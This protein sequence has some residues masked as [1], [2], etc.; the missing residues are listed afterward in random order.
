MCSAA[1]DKG[2]NRLIFSF[3]LG[4]R[5]IG[6]RVSCPALR[7]VPCW[8]PHTPLLRVQV[9]VQIFR[10]P[11]L[12]QAPTL[13]QLEPLP[14]SNPCRRFSRRSELSPLFSHYGEPFCA[15][16]KLN[17]FVFK[18]FGILSAKH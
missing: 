8:G 10:I 6:F 7:H 1:G 14:P 3:I 17:S 9:R 4:I 12:L 5:Y 2:R 15:D 18:Q 13:D 16:Q 11:P